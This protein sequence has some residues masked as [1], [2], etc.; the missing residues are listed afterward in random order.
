M[1]ARGELDKLQREAW[2]RDASFLEQLLGGG[3]SADPY[4]LPM[5]VH[6]E[7]RE[8]QRE[9]IAWLAFL[10]RCGLHGVLADDMGLGKT[11]QAIAIIAGASQH[12]VFSK[13]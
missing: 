5:P 12:S 4:D 10:R 9:G 1:E 11:L 2:A 13:G 6:A 8:Y 3:R 7:L